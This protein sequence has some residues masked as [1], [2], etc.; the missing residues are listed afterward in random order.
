MRS[1]SSAPADQWTA[2]D[3]R[4]RSMRRWRLA[5]SA[6]ALG[7]GA[8]LVATGHL[9]IGVVIGGLA[10][11]R[12][13]MF[14]R[15]QV[16]SGRGRAGLSATDR[17]WFR[18]RARDEFLVAS[19]VIGCPPGELRD[20]FQQGRSIADIAAE[21]SVDVREV[22]AAITADVTRSALDAEQTGAMSHDTAQRI[23]ALAPRFADRLVHRHRGDAGRL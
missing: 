10:V 7:L 20:E 23:H 8:V 12:F 9:L 1:D 22:T 16:P 13:V 3:H 15:F 19:G 21:R 18:A 11:A 4:V 14:S 17:Q 6:G 2:F 5:I